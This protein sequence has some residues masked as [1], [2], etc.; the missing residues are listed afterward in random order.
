MKQPFFTLNLR[1]WGAILASLCLMGLM[2]TPNTSRACIDLD[3]TVI[4]ICNYDSTNLPSV[5]EV[6]IRVTN[7]RLMQEQPNKFCSCAINSWSSIFTD[8]QYVAFVDSGTN[9]VYPDFAP[10]DASM[11]ASMSWDMD[12]PG[13]GNGWSGFIAEVIN[14]GLNPTRS[15]ELLI[16]ASLP[17]GYTVTLL[18]SSMFLSTVG[19]D[20]WDNANGTLANSHQQVRSMYDNPVQYH[21]MDAAHFTALDKA[22]EDYYAT[23]SIESNKVFAGLEVGPNP[24]REELAVSFDLPT[25]REVHV[26]LFDMQGRMIKLL[27]RE[28]LAPGLQE[29]RFEVDD[30]ELG[31]GTY[32]LR[33]RS[34]RAVITRKLVKL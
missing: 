7:L 32:F 20:E 5:D 13:N 11:G 23:L 15:V 3:T 10:W 18:D 2:V 33:L 9:N 30:L 28:E 17:M 25:A 12:Q 29:M 31:A 21:A 8:L 19:A 34:E 6:E 1:K 16:R 4:I 22:I 14:G 24:L 26:Q 27:R